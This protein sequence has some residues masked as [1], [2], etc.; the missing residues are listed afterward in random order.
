VNQLKLALRQLRLRPGLSVVVILMLA[1]GIGATTAMF[2]LYHQVLLKPLPVPGPDRLVN[3]AA[4]GP[5]PGGNVTDLGLGD[6]VAKFS[7]PMFRDLEARQTVF[8]GIAAHT[9]FMANLSFGDQAAFTLAWLV[10]D[11][12]FRVLGLAPA[13]G[14]LIGPEDEPRPGE[15]A[16]AVLSYDAWQRRFGGSPSALGETVTINGHKLEIVGV[17]PR[18]FAG[19]TLG[20]RPEVFVPLT[21][22]NLLSPSFS[23]FENRQSYW[24]YLF[25]RLKPGVALERASAEL[26]GLYSGILNDVEAP[27]LLAQEL[28][29]GTLEQFRARKIELAPGARGQSTLRKS[30]ARPVELLLGVTVLVL[31]IVC[32]NIANLLL[33]R[34]AARTGEMAL[35]TSMGASRGMLVR[36][37][38]AESLVLIAIGGGLSL[39]VAELLVRVIT[40]LLT[41]G[42]ANGIAPELS[43][44]AMLFAAGASLFTVLIFGLAPAWRVSDADPAQVMRASATRSSGGRGAARFRSVLT[45]AQIAFSMVLLVL[46]GLFTR[47]LMNVARQ[48][49]GM[50][51]GSTV[52]FSITPR[53][54]GY[55]PERIADL[56][57]RVE[58][59]L[60]AQPGVLAVGSSGLPVL[61]NF[62]LNNVLSVEGFDAPPGADTTAEMSMVGPGFFDALGIPRLAGRAFTDR[63]TV[64]RPPVAIVNESFAR[65]FNLDNGVGRH[66]GFGDTTAYPF[67]IVGI[68]AD[69]KQD[70]VKSPAP[71]VAYLS[72]RQAGA[73]IQAMFYYV[74]TGVDPEALLGTIPR[75][76]AEIDPEV[77]V[78]QLDTLAGEVRDNVYL[79]RLL[80]M[81][82]GGFAALA[83]LLAGIGLYGVLAYNVTQRTRE[84]GLRLALGAAPARLRAMVLKQVGAMAAIGAAIGL[85]TA[86][87]I[88]RVAESVLFGLSGRDPLVLAA[89]ATV[90]A[91]VVLAGSWWPARRASRIAPTEALRYE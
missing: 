54:N 55:S 50:D 31:A 7:Y 90:L 9:N 15:S 29:A 8:T 6:D 23:D 44:T 49:L 26:N 76:V 22:A 67:E 74:R 66:F 81:L 1:L 85:A 51:V 87:A 70:S 16:V 63:D 34:G 18:G 37:L 83:T 11:S 19:T 42:L 82:S 69:A 71:P 65:K 21:I 86:I 32:M 75:V 48:D 13:L 88:G 14:R 35:R 41:E 52:V 5:K 84:L 4:P 24:V 38:L 64:D 78:S 20:S 77:P 79:D 61:R 40:S 28:P 3:L 58:D 56:Y 36:Q 68:V 45:T 89:A 17:A 43:S 60:A 62:A 12:Y 72:R 53:L 10:S 91:V 46:A 47:S 25:A 73:T 59:S 57:D 30:V 39:A 2:S 33:A 27:M 80:S